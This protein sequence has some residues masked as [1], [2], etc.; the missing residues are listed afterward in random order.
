LE[1][2]IAKYGFQ[3]I[4]NTDQCGQF[5]SEVFTNVLRVIN[6]AI[7]LDGKDRRMNNVFIEKIWKSVTY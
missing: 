6:I 7:S 3:E 2:A 5:T 4:F 1:E